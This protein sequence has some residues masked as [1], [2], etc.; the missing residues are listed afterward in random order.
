MMPTWSR[1]LAISCGDK[2]PLEEFRKFSN[3]SCASSARGNSF[4]QHAMSLNDNHK[5]KKDTNL[6]NP[7]SRVQNPGSEIVVWKVLFGG[8]ATSDAVG[9]LEVSNV[10]RI[11]AGFSSIGLVP[12]G[13]GESTTDGILVCPRLGLLVAPGAPESSG[14]GSVRA[15]IGGLRCGGGSISGRSAAARLGESE[16]GDGSGVVCILS[17]VSGVGTGSGAGAVG[18]QVTPGLRLRFKVELSETEYSWRSLVS[19]RTLPLRRRR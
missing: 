18:S 7:R 12:L 15:T 17:G 14:G 13:E 19:A 16:P 11:S 4:L 8:P 6:R 9:I 10:S 3:A 5:S 1:I 2:D